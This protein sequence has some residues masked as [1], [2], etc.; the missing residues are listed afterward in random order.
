MIEGI[1]YKLRMFGIPVD[2]GTNVS[3]DNE[4]V[5][6]NSTKPE[7]TLKKKHSAISYHRAR[8]AQA[9]GKL[10]RN[11]RKRTWRMALQNVCRDHG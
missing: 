7:S 5:V 2:G 8:E 11:Q 10:P 4:A 6:H 1:R 9:A 3:C